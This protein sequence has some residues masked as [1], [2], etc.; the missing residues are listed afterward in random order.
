MMAGRTSPPAREEL[1][2]HIAA[3]RRSEGQDISV[4]NRVGW[5]EGQ[6]ENDVKLFAVINKVLSPFDRRLCQQAPSPKFIP[7]SKV[8]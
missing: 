2:E 1:R 6:I 8:W 7:S 3:L 5:I 4:D